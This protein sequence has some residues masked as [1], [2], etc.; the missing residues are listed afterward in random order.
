MAK[1]LLI[2]AHAPSPNTLA[3]LEAVTVGAGHPDITGVEWCAKAPLEVSAA[4]VLAADG[5]ILGSTENFGYM[6]GRLKD[7][8]ERIYYPCRE[9]TQ[10]LPYALYIRAGNDGLGCQTSVE[11][12]VTGLGWQAV[13]PPLICRGEFRP[14]FLDQCQELGATLAT[15]LELGIY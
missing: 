5:I 9:H 1:R 14:Q 11:R 4:D 15:G 6:A 8:F 10:G 7:F 3:L 12:I 13:Q 2:V